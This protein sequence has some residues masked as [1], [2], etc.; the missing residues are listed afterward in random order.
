MLL[1]VHNKSGIVDG[2]IAFMCKPQAGPH[3]LVMSLDS[4][5]GTSSKAVLVP[6]VHKVQQLRV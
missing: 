1:R 6:E 2:Y 5:K 3:K 4:M